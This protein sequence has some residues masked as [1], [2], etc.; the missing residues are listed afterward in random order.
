MLHKLAIILAVTLFAGS[1]FA[2]AS[3]EISTSN[4]VSGAT[5]LGFSPTR[6][7]TV[8][9]ISLAT[10]P[11]RYAMSAKHQQGNKI[12]GSTSAQTSNFQKDGVAG[13]ALTTTDVPSLPNS[14]SDTAI[15]SGW[16]PM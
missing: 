11:D 15:P 4:V 5:L 13:T 16:S 14:T 6:G 7:V 12:Y 8:G 10:S 1:A 3:A 2:G 9:Y